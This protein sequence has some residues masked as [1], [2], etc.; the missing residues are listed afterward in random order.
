MQVVEEQGCPS[1][2]LAGREWDDTPRRLE[3]QACDPTYEQ[4]DPEDNEGL[5][6][7]TEAHAPSW[8]GLRSLRLDRGSYACG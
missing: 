3:F 6:L 2:A 5:C 4:Y 7:V 1:V 8:N